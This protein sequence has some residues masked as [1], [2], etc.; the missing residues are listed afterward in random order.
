MPNGAAFTGTGKLVRKATGYEQKQAK[1]RYLTLG[2]T[3]CA[4]RT[5]QER[6]D[7][8]D[9][10]IA[11]TRLIVRGSFYVIDHQKLG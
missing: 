4:G 5:F 11:P 3:G 6:S 7:I 2:S 9:P 1:P 10:Q 8:G